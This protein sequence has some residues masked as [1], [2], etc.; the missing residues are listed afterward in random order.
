MM[1]RIVYLDRSLLPTAVRRPPFEHEWIAALKF[2]GFS[3]PSNTG[4]HASEN[5]GGPGAEPPVGV[6]TTVRSSCG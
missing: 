2:A 1:Q 3:H 6:R 4:V 5:P